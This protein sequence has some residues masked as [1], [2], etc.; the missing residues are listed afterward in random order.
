M[1]RKRPRGDGL[2]AAHVRSLGS[3]EQTLKAIGL[4]AFSFP[5]DNLSWK[6]DG[7]EIDG[8][9]EPFKGPRTVSAIGRRATAIGFRSD[10]IAQSR[11]DAAQLDLPAAQ[12][13]PVFG[14]G[15][16]PITGFR[17][18]I[19]VTGARQIQFSLDFEF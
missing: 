3:F 9:Y 5:R 13:N 1:L 8:C 17:Q 19:A 2:R 12:I 6:L 16:I 15:L 7:N 10:I 4:A 14:S 18:P 11:F